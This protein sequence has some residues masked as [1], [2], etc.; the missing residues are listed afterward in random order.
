PKTPKP[1]RLEWI[2]YPIIL[3]QMTERVHYGEAGGEPPG[4][5]YNKVSLYEKD[6]DKTPE[7]AQKRRVFLAL[8]FS[9]GILQTLYMNLAAFY[10]THAESYGISSSYSGIVLAMFQVAYL[11]CSPIVGM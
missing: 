11:I 1:Q 8:L 2:E 4:S 9:M 6:G 10:P 3:K 7:T 5:F